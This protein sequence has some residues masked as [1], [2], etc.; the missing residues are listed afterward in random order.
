MIP[1]PPD[2][3][4]SVTTTSG[5]SEGSLRGRLD[6]AEFT[7]YH[8]VGFKLEEGLQSDAPPTCRPIKHRRDSCLLLSGYLVVLG[9]PCKG[10]VFQ[11]VRIPPGNCR[12]SR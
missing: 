1:L 7:H 3:D 9:A 4:T 5:R 6:A 10:T 11:W 2:C 12:S 8:H